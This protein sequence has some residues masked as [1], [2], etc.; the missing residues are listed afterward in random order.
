MWGG[1]VTSAHRETIQ[2][3]DPPKPD[4]PYGV[5]KMEAER[6]LQEIGQ[7]SGLETV[8]RELAARKPLPS[9]A[10]RQPDFYKDDAPLQ[11]IIKE[12]WIEQ[13]RK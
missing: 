3:D 2:A 1:R 7:A 6:G 11:K 12:G 13:L 8:I 5:S 4:T 10:F 9:D